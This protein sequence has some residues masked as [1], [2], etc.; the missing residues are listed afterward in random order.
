MRH[1]TRQTNRCYIL[2]QTTEVGF[3]TGPITP[4]LLELL[5]PPAFFLD[6]AYTRDTGLTWFLKEHKVC[7][8]K[9]G[10]IPRVHQCEV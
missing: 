9:A 5:D 8:D 3:V 1:P 7:E 6:G 2:R 4:T 10:F